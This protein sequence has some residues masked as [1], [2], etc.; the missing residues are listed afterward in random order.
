MGIQ[1]QGFSLRFLHNFWDRGNSSWYL[2]GRSSKPGYQTQAGAVL[3]TSSGSGKT[4][5]LASGGLRLKGGRSCRMCAHARALACTYGGFQQVVA[6]VWGVPKMGIIVVI[7]LLESIWEPHIMEPPIYQ[8][9]SMFLANTE[10][11]ASCTLYI[12]FIGSETRDL[13]NCW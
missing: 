13:G 6:P 11:H 4:S 9:L 5:S 7:L 8:L 1:N 2:G 12:Y 10:G 3:G